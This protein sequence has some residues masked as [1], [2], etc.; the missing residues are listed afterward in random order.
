VRTRLTRMCRYQRYGLSPKETAP[1]CQTATV[2]WA[3]IEY[4]FDR[5]LGMATQSAIEWT[6]VTW[7]PVTGCDR[8]AAGCDNCYALALANRLKAMGAAKYQ[9]DGNPATSGPGFG[10]TI[11]P[12]S[13]SQP[14]RWS[15]SRV[16]FVN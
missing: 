14:Y 4:V 13:L 8:V 6:E 7:N 16:V 15:S 5:R 3:H 2:D 12:Q 10:V 11:H 9:N 1:A